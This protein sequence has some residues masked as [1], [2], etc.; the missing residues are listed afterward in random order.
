LEAELRAKD[1]LLTD[2][3]RDTFDLKNTLSFIQQADQQK[4]QRIRTLEGEREALETERNANQGRKRTWDEYHDGAAERDKK[5]SELTQS[6]NLIAHENAHYRT[7]NREQGEQVN[8]LKVRVKDLEAE[9]SSLQG[10][11]DRQ[12]EKYTEL[13][14]A[15]EEH[16]IRI[17]SIRSRHAGE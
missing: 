8:G 13:S 10:K 14:Q 2:A 4:D 17:R 9:K 3:R 6:Y 7:E 11:Y 16:D 15:E 1:S 12:C 5:W